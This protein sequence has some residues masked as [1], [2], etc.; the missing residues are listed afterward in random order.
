METLSRVILFKP[1]QTKHVNR[2][3]VFKVVMK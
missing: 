3:G 1:M 2:M